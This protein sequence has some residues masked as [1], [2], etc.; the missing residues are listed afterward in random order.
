M[1]SARRRLAMPLCSFGTS[2][3]F[4]GGGWDGSAGLNL[5]GGGGNGGSLGPN[6]DPPQVA[7]GATDSG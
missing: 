7:F 1:R 3:T 6:E 4:F 2:F 5:E